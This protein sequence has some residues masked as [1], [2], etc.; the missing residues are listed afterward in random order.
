MKEI[1]QSI[2][3]VISA[4]LAAGLTFY[5]QKKL[6]N[7]QF[8]I[9]KQEIKF[10]KNRE[11]LEELKSYQTTIV[12]ELTFLRDLT[13]ELSKKKITEEKYKQLTEHKIV[14][15]KDILSKAYTLHN[16]QLDFHLIGL[17][18]LYQNI[19]DS[20]KKTLQNDKYYMSE[21]INDKVRHYDYLIAQSKKLKD[22]I[23]KKAE[24]V[25]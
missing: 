16:K 7:K 22:R 19:E 18:A 12:D 5:F 10:E 23:Q 21:K 6:M 2:M 13:K 17:T 20:F 9:K 11:A 1:I 25:S 8:E 24:E 15:L 3:P 14:F 4:L